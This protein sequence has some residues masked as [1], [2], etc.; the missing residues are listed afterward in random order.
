MSCWPGCLQQETT[1]VDAAVSVLS[2][3]PVL[4]LLF[5]ML[6]LSYKSCQVDGDA[7][8]FFSSCSWTRPKR[9]LNSQ[10]CHNFLF[11][12]AHQSCFQSGRRIF[13]PW[14]AQATRPASIRI[15]RL[16]HRP[17]QDHLFLGAGPSGSVYGA[18]LQKRP[19][20]LKPPLLRHRARP[21]APSPQSRHSPESRQLSAG[22]EDRLSRPWWAGWK[23]RGISSPSEH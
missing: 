5:L 14:N 4:F 16:L 21:P 20:Q 7:S 3:F 22:A 13:S 2:P 6:L 15:P 1:S 9:P 11:S 18:S 10:A 12:K 17:N 23:A 8:Q 19:S